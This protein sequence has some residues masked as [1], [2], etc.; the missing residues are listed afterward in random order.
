MS[1]PERAKR[2]THLLSSPTCH[3]K[4][5]G[6]EINTGYYQDTEVLIAS[7]PMGAGGSGFAFHELYV[8]GADL[9]VRMG[10]NDHLVTREDMHRTFLIENADHLL[11][12]NQELGLNGK[13]HIWSAN[14]QLFN[15]LK[16][17]LELNAFETQTAICHHLEDY[18]A[19]NFPNCLGENEQQHIM[20]QQALWN[21]Q[22]QTTVWDMET[23]P[24]YYRAHLLHKIACSVVQNIPKMGEKTDPYESDLRNE[25]ITFEAKLGKTI[26]KGLTS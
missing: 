2:L 4:S 15:R 5:W 14:Q 1:N 21:L 19:F 18:H 20:A 6:I 22:H 13:N 10:S 17:I 26:L 3:T 8:A 7:V 12:L 16:Q 24:L 11:G 9:L 23:A 25:I